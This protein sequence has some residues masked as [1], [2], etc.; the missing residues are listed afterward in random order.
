MGERKAT[1]MTKGHIMLCNG[2]SDLSQVSKLIDANRLVCCDT[3]S[4][5]TDEGPES[6]KQIDKG[7][8]SSVWEETKE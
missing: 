6:T 4:M 5:E 8:M 3:G 7:V 1:V 2:L